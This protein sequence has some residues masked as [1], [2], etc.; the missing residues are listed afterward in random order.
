MQPPQRVAFLFA[1]AACHDALCIP[2]VSPVAR[3]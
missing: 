1:E 3:F 2:A